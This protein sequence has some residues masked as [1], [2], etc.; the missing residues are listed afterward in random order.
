VH[1]R[2][3][4]HAAGVVLVAGVLVLGA[5]I[6]RAAA[7]VVG[8]GYVDTDLVDLQW[9]TDHL[10]YDSVEELQR[11]GVAVVDF[12]LSITGRIGPEATDTECDLGYAN[13]LDPF[14]PHR[15]ATVW[16]GAA[17]ATL[18]RV[19]SHYCISREQT[20]AFGATVLTFFAG[21]DAGANGT[22]V[23]QRDRSTPLDRLGPVDRL[24]SCHA[25]ARRA[26]SCGPSDSGLQT[27]WNRHVPGSG[28]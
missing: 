2:F 9:A 26:A 16:S 22:P 13:Q 14:G 21:L 25:D 23:R 24:R 15:F 20:Q 8:T 5:G 3:L 10:G 11:A 6:D 27:R 4:H 19:A 17:L 28:T 12:I 1:R 7:D 18:D